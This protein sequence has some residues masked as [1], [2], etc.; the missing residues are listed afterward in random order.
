MRCNVFYSIIIP[1]YNAEH[2]IEQCI[3][4]VLS[5]SFTDYEIL[6]IDDGSVDNTGRIVQKMME[7]YSAISVMQIIH[8]GAGAA[9]NVGLEKAQG[10][11]VIFLDADDYWT[12]PY[13]L[14]HLYRK[15]WQRDVD[16]VMFQMDKYTETGKLLLKYRKK[17]FEYA[18]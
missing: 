1:A 3:Q 14:K 18:A 6:V 9:R 7:E 8:S 5:Q 17:P 13:L 11:Y 10:K 4:S 16:V 2:Y 15:L 12:N